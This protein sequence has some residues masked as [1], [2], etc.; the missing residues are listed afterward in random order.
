MRSVF[1]TPRAERRER[2]VHS[3]LEVL[4]AGP[5]V[6]RR[7]TEPLEPLVDLRAQLALERQPV[8]PWARAEEALVQC[9][10]P[11]QL[12]DRTLVVVD[13]KVDEDVRESGVPPIALDHEQRRRLLPTAVAAGCLCSHE[14]FEQPLH[15][16]QA[17]G[18]LEGLRER[19]DCLLADED[20]ALRGIAGAG[21]APRPVE[22]IGSGV[23]GSAAVAVD[24]PD[25]ALGTAL[26]GAGQARDGVVGREPFAQER[27]ALG[28]VARVGER[29][30]GDRSDLG[31]GEGTDRADGEELRLHGDAPLPRLEVARRDRV[32]RDDRLSHT[33]APSSRARAGRAVPPG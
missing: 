7:V 25:L 20:V 5:R 21:S 19:C 10:D 8:L 13:A 1:T 29:L 31:L 23:A 24:D 32:R 15:E 16:R 17:L 28:A 6:E 9:V 30:R 2:P 22:A 33:S 12:L 3:L 11:A 26:V 27:E 4:D 14:T 18:L